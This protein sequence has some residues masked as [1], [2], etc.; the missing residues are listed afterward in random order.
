MS[1]EVTVA[2]KVV[3]ILLLIA[4]IKVIEKKHTIIQLKDLKQ[5]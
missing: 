3:V 5:Y 4:V 2:V 1:K